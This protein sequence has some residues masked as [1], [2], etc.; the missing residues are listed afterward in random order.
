MVLATSLTEFYTDFLKSVL[1]GEIEDKSQDGI[2]SAIYYA[3]Y[4]KHGIRRKI[5]ADNAVMLNYQ[6][7][8]HKYDRN[9]K[10]S[11]L[12]RS[13]II[14]PKTMAITSMGLPQS[15]PLTDE[16][17]GLLIK[18]ESF[19]IGTMIIY[20][21][22]RT[23]T[24]TL[25]DPQDSQDPQDPQDEEAS[26]EERVIV[27]AS[28]STR[29][30]IGTGN[31]N[32]DMT[33]RYYFEKNNM[34]DPANI[35]DLTKIPEALK[36]TTLVFNMRS[37][38]E[39]IGRISGNTLVAGFNTST[40][41]IELSENWLAILNSVVCG[42]PEETGQLLA[43]H[44]ELAMVESCNLP[45]LR[46]LLESNGVGNLAI[47]KSLPLTT[48]QEVEEFVAKQQFH[49]QGVIIWLPDGSRTKVRNPQFTY[50]R[51][52]CYNHPIN[53]SPL[54]QKNLFKIYWSLMLEAKIPEFL[55]YYETPDYRYNFIFN[56]F[57]TRTYQFS[58]QLF[59]TYQQLHVIKNLPADKVFK[60][61]KPLC[62]ELHG[63][64]LATKEPITRERVL[65]YIHGMESWAIYGRLFTPIL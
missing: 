17:Q 44:A 45:E 28:I 26:A 43:K 13:V 19:D 50:V 51:N 6:K 46:D 40:K 57:H 59:Q 53:P 29:S 20:N 31:Y 1:T 32:S 38:S 22:D 41:D 65:K 33:H 55:K 62:Y 10:L 25:Q 23:Y 7:K 60:F 52:L 58:Q 2:M 48:I 3:L 35:I 11:Q 5:I 18:C 64:Y 37:E 34:S 8:H 47:P 9:N 14:N 4:S 16:M 39:H 24:Y 21:K 27:D 42:Q 49:E 30:K 61:L 63:I 56:Y 15:M 54:N 36:D 12:F